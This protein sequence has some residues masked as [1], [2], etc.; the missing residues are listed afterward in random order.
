[1]RMVYSLKFMRNAKILNSVPTVAHFFYR[2][3]DYRRIYR[4]RSVAW[5]AEFGLL[6]SSAEASPIHTS[7]MRSP[8]NPTTFLLGMEYL[9]GAAT[10]KEDKQKLI[11]VCRAGLWIPARG[12]KFYLLPIVPFARDQIGFRSLQTLPCYKGEG[13]TQTVS[14]FE[15]RKGDTQGSRG[16]I[17]ND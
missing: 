6:I 8:P 1:M 11:F 16:G 2:K 10:A 4:V 9:Y 17:N 13:V 3:R 15:S 14:R 12:R 5:K 7:T